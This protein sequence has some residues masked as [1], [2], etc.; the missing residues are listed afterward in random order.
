MKIK[1]EYQEELREGLFLSGQNIDLDIHQGLLIKSS[2]K[3]S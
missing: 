1:Q 3:R 2:G